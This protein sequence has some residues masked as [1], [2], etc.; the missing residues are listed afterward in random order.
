MKAKQGFSGVLIL[1]ALAVVA[2]A[3]YFFLFHPT[4]SNT[5]IVSHAYADPAGENTYCEP[6]NVPAFGSTDGPA[7]LPE[8]CYYTD[9]SATPSNGGIINVTSSKGIPAALATV[10]CGNTID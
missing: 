8:S 6:G 2:I 4:A 1:F 10:Q 3:G 9:T 7:T 5:A